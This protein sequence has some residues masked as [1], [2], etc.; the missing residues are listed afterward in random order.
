VL[1]G[2]PPDA[3]P[4]GQALAEQVFPPQIPA[5]LPATPLERRPDILSAEV[6]LIAANAQIGAARSLF[7]P[8]I[9]LTGVFGESSTE[10]INFT[11][12]GRLRQQ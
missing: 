5:G 3:I 7:F 4:R 11:N 9:S 8:Q 10:L 1:I 6:K 2:R 12:E